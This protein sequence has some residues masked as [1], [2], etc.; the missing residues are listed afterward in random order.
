MRMA[1]FALLFITFAAQA[2]SNEPSSIPDPTRVAAA[3]Q[4]IHVILFD[5]GIYERGVSIAAPQMV[6][7]IQQRI[8]GFRSDQLFSARGE[9]ALNEFVAALPETVRSELFV[10]GDSIVDVTAERTASLFSAEDWLEIATF[11]GNEDALRMLMR[12]GLGGDRNLTPE[13]QDLA[14][15]YMTPAGQAFSEHDEELFRAL[16]QTWDEQTPRLAIE[17][18]ERVSRRFCI[19]LADECPT[20]IRQFIDSN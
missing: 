7:D 19:A 10:A 11:F 20:A 9:A 8:E 6:D 14:R 17:L 4:A 16:F 12:V 5:T 3:R 15:W 1:A 18:N 13:E 2:L